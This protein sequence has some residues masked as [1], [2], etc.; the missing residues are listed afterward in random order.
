VAGQ[1]RLVAA[2]ARVRT[3]SLRGAIEKRCVLCYAARIA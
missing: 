2:R 1:Q 3:R